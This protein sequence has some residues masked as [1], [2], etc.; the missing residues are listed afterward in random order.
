MRLLNSIMKEA[1]RSDSRFIEFDGEKMDVVIFP[2]NKWPRMGLVLGN[3]ALILDYKTSMSF[4][5]RSGNLGF[6]KDI[7]IRKSKT[8]IDKK[9]LKKYF[10]E[11]QDNPYGIQNI[12]NLIHRGQAVTTA[13]QFPPLYLPKLT[14]EEKKLA[15]ER[16]VQLGR[17][18]DMVFSAHR[19]DAISATIRKYD[20]SQFSHVAIYLGNGEVADIGPSGGEINSLSDS[21]DDT[22][23]ALYTFKTDI[24]EISREAIVKGARDD[25][26]KGISFN[27]RGIF[28]MFL[29][30]RFKLPVMRNVPSVAELLFGNSFQLVTYL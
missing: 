30:K 27:Y 25:I 19:H 13:T 23:F 16:L 28:L 10:L 1:K 5:V 3:E 21:D 9:Y 29:K 14:G 4:R 17:K 11:N 22:H 18:G 7:S 2:S 26:A 24:P 12:M 6:S 15:I 20:H 8:P